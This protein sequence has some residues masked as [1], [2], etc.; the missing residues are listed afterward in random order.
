LQLR[1]RG[2]VVAVQP[3]VSRAYTNADK[4]PHKKPIITETIINETPTDIT[5]AD[6]PIKNA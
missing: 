6:P 5:N 1:I 3:L 4:T 2:K